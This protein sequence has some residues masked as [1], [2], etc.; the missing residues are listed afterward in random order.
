LRCNGP[1]KVA[2][3]PGM[4]RQLVSSG[5]PF[6]PLAGFSRAV[7]VGDRIVVAGT[8]P[9]WPG[10][11][12]DPSVEAQTRRC[13]EIIG[14]ALQEVGATYAH[15]VRTR[16]F[17]VDAADFPEVARVHGEVF[18]HVRPAC[19]GVIVAGL[20]DDRWKIEIEADAVVG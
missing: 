16:L 12:V 11:E 15:V 10:D 6:E 2:Y 8:A 20:L 5:S 9:I 4:Q 3:G 19:T 18:G 17:M 13:L 1:E 7:R 14:A